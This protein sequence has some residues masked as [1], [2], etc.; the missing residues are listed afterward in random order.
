MIHYF[1]LP[2]LK[3]QIK[4][5]L[6]IFRWNYITDITTEHEVEMVRIWFNKKTFNLL[7]V[8]N[9]V[10]CQRQFHAWDLFET[11]VYKFLG[12]VKMNKKDDQRWPWKMTQS[13]RTKMF[14][15]SCLHWLVS[16]LKKLRSK[17]MGGENICL[18]QVGEGGGDRVEGL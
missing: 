18:W 8:L 15:T 6:I 17:C 12:L 10:I 13:R 1:F 2:S 5:I 11:L 7:F 9:H 14:I 4:H 16:A 3:K